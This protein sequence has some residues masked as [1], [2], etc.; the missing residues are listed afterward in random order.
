M[1]KDKQDNGAV[2]EG[3]AGILL[4]GGSSRRL[5][6]DKAALVVEG[7]ALALRVARTMSNVVHPIVEVGP[8]RSGLRAVTEDPPGCGPLVAIGAGCRF[9]RSE[10][11]GGPVLVLACDLPRVAE[12]L[13]TLL[14]RW[15][16]ERSVVPV[17][18]GMAQPLCARWSRSHLDSIPERVDTGERSMRSLLDDTVEFVDE[19]VWARVAP[20]SAFGDIDR[21]EDLDQLGIRWAFPTTNN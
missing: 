15:P 9:L 13:L 21:R 5:G 12:P 7:Q 3:V 16:G 20:P 2:V 17:V 1:A 6:F 14:A 4:T 11:H 8:G 19:S 18:A 10:G